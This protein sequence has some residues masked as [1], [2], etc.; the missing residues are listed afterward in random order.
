VVDDQIGCPTYAPDIANAIIEI[1]RKVD[2]SGWQPQY[3]G[4]THLAGPDEVTWYTFARRILQ[5]S[6]TKRDH[7]VRVDPITSADYPTPVKRPANSRLC[8]DR[9]TSLFDF[10]LPPLELSLQQCIQRLSDEPLQSGKNPL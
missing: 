10:R 2:A 4:V 8:C 1:A 5:A 9:L 6:E 3:N 7:F